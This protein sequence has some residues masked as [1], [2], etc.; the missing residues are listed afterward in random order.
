MKAFANA[1]DLL[2]NLLTKF[3]TQPERTR[4]IT[5]PAQV[6]FPNPD[7]RDR[8]VGGL[9]AAEAAGAVELVSD[10]DAPHLVS[11]VILTDADALYRHLGRTP[12]ELSIAA[13]L[14]DFESVEART[15][16]AAALK[17]ALLE[18]WPRGVRVAACAQIV[19]MSPVV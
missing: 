5:A 16:E 10:R 4:R 1:G 17:S 8:L 18:E 3:E 11:K 2:H 13:A 6:S 15:P 19:P 14:S 7:A 9:R 12:L